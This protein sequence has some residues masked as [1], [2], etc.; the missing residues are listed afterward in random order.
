MNFLGKIFIGMIFVQSIVF[1]GLAV[2]IYATHQDLR[3]KVMR[4]P[5]EVG[6][7][8]GEVGL[9]YRLED[10]NLDNNQLVEEI[11]RLRDE[12]SEEEAAYRRQLQKLETRRVEML[13]ERQQT[14]QTLAQ[15]G[16]EKLNFSAALDK[17][18]EN[19]QTVEADVTR[20]RAKILQTQ[21]QRDQSFESTVLLIE[22][23]NEKVGVL[24]Q[25]EERRQQLKGQLAVMNLMTDLNAIDRNAPPKD[26]QP[27]LRGR[28]IEVKGEGLIEI[29]LGS[30]VGIQRGQ[31]IEI[32]RGGAYLGRAEII[33]TRP[34]K[35]AATMLRAYQQ[36]SI[37]RGD[38]VATRLN[39]S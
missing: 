11:Q 34:E 32:F 22:Q 9:K 13:E 25:L 35:A 6:R 7:I 39:P 19:I 24:E 21:A 2:A 12:L 23:I 17:V 37:R 10:A 18:Q 33:Q 4:T 38:R 31:T 16:R 30:D 29:S 20:L 15:L 26:F 27:N 36:D 14:N 28:V 5:D 1:A 3:G 8:G